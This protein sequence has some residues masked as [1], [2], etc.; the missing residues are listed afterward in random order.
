LGRFKKEKQML[1]KRVFIVFIALA[2]TVVFTGSAIAGAILTN[3]TAIPTDIKLTRL[4]GSETTLQAEIKGKKSMAVFFNTA[5]AQCLSEIKYLLKKHPNENILYISIDL[6]GAK[7][8][9]GWKKRF[10]ASLP[11]KDEMMFVDPEF[12]VP[13]RFGLSLTPST[14]FTEP[15]VI[16]E[17]NV[18]ILVS[19]KAGFKKSDIAEIKAF[20][21]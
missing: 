20:F 19:T 15:A 18:D 1:E 7:M 3:G 11:L 10:L 4:D 8:V 9:I 14:I 13:M 16:E 6:G 2:I 5:C 21:E 12:T 17:Q